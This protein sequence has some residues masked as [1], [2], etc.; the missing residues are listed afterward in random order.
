MNKHKKESFS[1]LLLALLAFL[2]QACSSPYS[3]LE[4]GLYAEFETSKGDFI[5][6]LYFQDVPM[7]VG[8][9][10]AHA[11]GIHPLTEDR[12][13]DQRLYDSL[14]FHRVVKD[15]I[16]QAG[17]PRGTG[18]GGPG[19]TFP[20][21]FSQLHTHDEKGVLSMANS[22]PNSNG[23][24]FFIT[25]RP[26]PDLDNKHSVFGKVVENYD[27]VDSI[28]NVETNRADRPLQKVFIEKVN[29]IRKG[30]AAENFNAVEAF[31]E[32]FA[33]YENKL[34]ENAQ[35]RKEVLKE[36]SEGY[37]VTESGLRYDITKKVNTGES[38]K[39]GDML[40]V[41]YEGFLT[42]GTK[43]D[44]S[45]DRGE[46]IEFKLGVGKVIPGWDEGLQLLKEGEKARFIIPPHLS[47][48][49]RATGPIPPYSI[50]IFDV[51]L[52]EVISK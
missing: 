20:D 48:N 41:H 37:E 46:P 44:S 4:D 29:I 16:I 18:R 34:K 39:P 8:N 15:F 14:I 31:T 2:I 36:L 40:K 1:L 49:E 7:T 51:E 25:L 47:Y 27:V 33:A 28:G 50:L 10:V 26:A 43:F 19:F 35:K 22:G 11:E 12:Y 32:G 5:A 52:V 42:D 17:D 13:K 45:L 38:P 3:E 24:Q 9:F 23:S 21:E 30:T 6:E